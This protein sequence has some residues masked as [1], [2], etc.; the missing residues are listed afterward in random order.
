[1]EQNVH[2]NPDKGSE[3]ETL[4][5]MSSLTNIPERDRA[6]SP[7]PSYTTSSTR[8]RR[9]S[10]ERGCYRSSTPPVRDTGPS[11]RPNDYQ[12]SYA[13][14]DVLNG[15]D[16]ASEVPSKF[17]EYSAIPERQVPSSSSHLPYRDTTA[18]IL[19]S[20][21]TPSSQQ[22]L[23]PYSQQQNPS[24]QQSLDKLSMD[25]NVQT[26]LSGTS[27]QGI[28]A[29]V[30]KLW[31]G[32]GNQPHPL[33]QSD[34]KELEMDEIG[35]LK[36]RMQLM[37]YEQ[38]KQK[39]QENQEQN[40]KP[41]P[42]ESQPSFQKDYST[43]VPDSNPQHDYNMDTDDVFPESDRILLPAIQLRQ[44]LESL[45]QLVN[46]QKRRCREIKLG[47]EREELS[48]K[49]VEKKFHGQEFIN[50]NFGM[51]PTDPH[52]W[53]R[54]QKKKLRELE[55]IKAEQ[56]KR[57]QQFEYEEHRSRSKLKALEAQASEIR[58]QLQQA[59]SANPRGNINASES[60]GYPQSD[61]L[62]S[63]LTSDQSRGREGMYP[64][65]ERIIPQQDVQRSR[66]AQLLKPAEFDHLAT[67][68]ADLDWTDPTKP[69][70]AR[71]MSMDS[72]ST[73]TWMGSEQRDLR[74][75]GNT[76]SEY[77]MPTQDDP[78]PTKWSSYNM[79]TDLYSSHSRV[80]LNEDQFPQDERLRRLKEEHVQSLASMD[81]INVKSADE[82]DLHINQL[83]Q[84]ARGRHHPELRQQR[85]PSPTQIPATSF[86]SSEGFHPQTSE[87]WNQPHRAPG[88]AGQYVNAH[89][90]HRVPAYHSNS[91]ARV[92][93]YYSRSSRPARG[94]PRNVQPSGLPYRPDN[95]STHGIIEQPVQDGSRIPA[96]ATPDVIPPS[97]SI[98]LSRSTNPHKQ[99]SAERSS[100]P[101]SRHSN[102]TMPHSPPYSHV[103]SHREQSHSSRSPSV[104]SPNSRQE[105]EVP[106]RSPTDRSNQI[107]AVMDQPKFVS[108]HHYSV[109]TPLSPS[110]PS[111]PTAITLA[112]AGTRIFQNRVHDPRTT[113]YE[114]VST[115]KLQN[116]P[117][118]DMHHFKPVTHRYGI[119]RPDAKVGTG[120]SYSRGRPE[121]MPQM[122]SDM[123]LYME[124]SFRNPPVRHPE[125]IQRQQTEL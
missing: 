112:T 26:Q 85:L 37:Y 65:R 84:E 75:P 98:P 21:P 91:T 62:P 117:E 13:S 20:Q 33:N 105:P 57:L 77:S 2:Y 92:D 12:S 10:S 29:V 30:P 121:P 24:Q 44:E 32:K 108:P 39:E 50:G 110:R 28:T 38:Q 116:A 1:M 78:I 14:F 90:Y 17:S 103:T 123:K 7:V 49:Q 88:W 9:D 95:Y 111:N 66:D 56:S 51:N 86:V 19:N 47:R 3:I 54:E 73:G 8:P 63:K 71:V 60:R 4:G 97:Y 76:M 125:R 114:R 118:K 68:P 40:T 82:R 113:A 41:L 31:S 16:A 11:T 22:M 6:G 15:P 93:H 106:T 80:T 99:T 59:E 25:V 34:L 55:R 36:Q 124:Q 61:L 89:P 119:S 100:S 52:R 42:P 79:G 83:Q 35:L 104:T 96:S 48:L 58:Q 67:T 64:E 53:Q 81:N 115:D 23:T 107:P 69:I 102:H 120:H 101:A 122:S 18:F 109:Q 74:E 43:K 70:P 87:V 27:A 45:E 5:S 94:Y 72:V 46:D